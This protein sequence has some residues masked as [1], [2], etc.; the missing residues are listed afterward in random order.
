MLP[1]DVVIIKKTLA[2]AFLLCLVASTADA[3]PVLSANFC[4]GNDSCPAGLTEASL[5]FTAE[6]ATADANDYTLEIVFRATVAGP[7]YLDQ[8]SWT[9]A[10]FGTPAGYETTP[11]LQ[12]ASGGA[13]WTVYYDNIAANAASCTTNTNA[14]NEVCLQSG[15]G[16]PNNFG[17][18]LAGQTVR[19]VLL[20]DLS[21]EAVLTTRTDVNLRAQFRDADGGSAGILS[22]NFNATIAAIPE[23][24][25]LLLV[26][27]GL[28][29]L[30]RARRKMSV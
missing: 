18:P 5:S 11:V 26:G 3:A 23:P 20:I 24:G 14:S 2:G 28:V 8:L 7:A 27:A 10:G 21:G 17:A 22:P 15:P 4:P 13:G 30:R 1:P 16:N 19:F 9:I 29:A 12:S 25:T 6:G